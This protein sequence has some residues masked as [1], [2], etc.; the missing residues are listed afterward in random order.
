M[1]DFPKIIYMP[2]KD[3]VRTRFIWDTQQFQQ[4]RADA[5]MPHS[6]SELEWKD[7]DMTREL[8]AMLRSAFL[9][10]GHYYVASTDTK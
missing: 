10:G 9:P 5:S 2:C 8:A 1:S 7:V 6:R 3:R 4:C